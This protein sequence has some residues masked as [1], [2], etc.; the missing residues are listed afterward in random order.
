MFNKLIAS[1]PGARK[2][3]KSPGTVAASVAAHALVLG[4][5]V[6]ATMQQDAHD[7]DDT[8]PEEVTYID[9][10]EIPEPEPEEVF[11]EP[12]A[13]EEP[14]PRSPTP[15]RETF[16]PRRPA[17]PEEISE[18]PAGFQ[19]LDIPDL[20]V[21]GLPPPDLD[22]VPVEAEDFGGRGTPGGRA[23]GARSEPSGEGGEGGGGGPGDGTY[24]SNLVDEPAELRNRG[25][26][27]RILSRRYPDNLRDAHVEGRVVVQFVVG[28]NGQ[29]EMGSFKVVSST[30]P[31]FG[32]ATRSA[33]GEFRFSPGKV[34][35]Q[36]VRQVVQ[37]P[38]VWQLD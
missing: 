25:D 1:S 10:T 33:V 13:P 17:P 7:E 9:V 23:S 37:M 22:A 36:P 19:E 3:W 14:A 32:S 6:Y 30:D 28:K 21:R 31:A 29:V 18:E 24:S 2:L 26:V 38:I 15:P 12:P 8:E 11:E 16:Q 20:D 35:G 4:G 5:V 27:A 34:Q